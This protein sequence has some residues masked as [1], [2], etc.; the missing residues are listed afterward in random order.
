MNMVHK[1]LHHI[2]RIYI[3][4]RNVLIV[5]VACAVVI[6][7]AFA[8]FTLKAVNK[9]NA[10]YKKYNEQLSRLNSAVDFGKNMPTINALRAL[11]GDRYELEKYFKELENV[12]G[13]GRKSTIRNPV[14][15]KGELLRTRRHL[16]GMAHSL[17]ITIPDDIGFGEYIGQKI[18]SSGEI[19]ILAA[20]IGKIRAL[21]VILLKGGVQTL[22]SVTRLTAAGHKAEKK[23]KT[24]FYIDYKF[25]V[26]FES[27]QEVLIDILESLRRSGQFFIIRDINVKKISDDKFAVRMVISGLVFA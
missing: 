1:I 15:F 7:S 24:D 14:E 9:K 18:P 10:S 12:L 11:E 17:R 19:P 6:F 27:S 8:Y 3:F 4:K 16:L 20:Q 22:N 21:I 2:N 26:S 5:I 25:E 23:D 13:K